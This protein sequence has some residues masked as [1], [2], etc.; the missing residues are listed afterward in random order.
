MST[1]VPTAD[2]V[3]RL[4]SFNLLHGM[5]LRTGDASD[6]APLRAAAEELSADVVALQEVDV[7]QP[8]SSHVDQVSVF[9]DAAGL[10]HHVFHPTVDGT[11]GET[12]SPWCLSIAVQDPDGSTT[13]S[14]PAK[15]FAKPWTSSPASSG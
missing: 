1:E 14:A 4:A 8:R 9:A 2:G 7:D 3:L 15:V 6:P 13:A 5:V 10:G 12:W 11:P